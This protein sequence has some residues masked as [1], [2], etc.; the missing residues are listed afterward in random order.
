MVE[1]SAKITSF[2][3]ACQRGNGQVAGAHAVHGRDKSPQH[4]VDAVVLLGV[5]NGH[6]VLYV[7]HHADG[8][9][10][11]A[12]IAAYFADVVVAD[13]VA[14]LAVF[15]VTPHGFDGIGKAVHIGFLSLQ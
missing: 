8:A 9:V 13:I 3:W 1:L 6:H 7:L 4:V 11:S 12:R 2:I 15:D 5:F 14:H 10:V